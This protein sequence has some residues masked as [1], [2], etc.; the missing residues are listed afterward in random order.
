MT[1][2]FVTLSKPT[3]DDLEAASAEGW[4]VVSV[5]WYVTGNMQA[6]L[7]KKNNRQNP[8]REMTA[9]DIRLRCQ[10]VMAR[11]DTADENA[12]ANAGDELFELLEDIM[13]ELK[14]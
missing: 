5:A 1:Y 6:A 14:R 3:V 8:D 12:A 13:G 9:D 10:K 2:K 7:L 4:E 11:L